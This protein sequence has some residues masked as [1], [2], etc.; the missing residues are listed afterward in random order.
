MGFFDKLKMG[1]E[2]ESTPVQKKADKSPRRI[3]SKPQ[4]KTK[5]AKIKLP[6]KIKPQESLI[7]TAEQ[8]ERLPEKPK[9]AAPSW[10]EPHPAKTERNE[11]EFEGEL[12]IDVYETD[13]DFVVQSTIAG[14][15]AGDLDI[16]IENDIV[17]IRGSREKQTTQEGKKYYY[18][19]CYWGSFSRQV[20]LPQEV[21][22]SKAEASIKDGVLTLKIPKIIKIQKRKIAIKQEE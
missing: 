1:G 19:E 13:G 16:T 14:V 22:G 3:Q 9:K 8:E 4:D 20:I 2:K 7:N 17:T 10:G 11:S 18:Q 21:D 12:A 6:Q 5:M 15:K